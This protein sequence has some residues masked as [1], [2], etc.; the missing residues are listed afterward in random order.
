MD[1]GQLL[2]RAAPD[3]AYA[4]GF[5]DNSTSNVMYSNVAPATYTAASTNG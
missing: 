2:Y 5:G 4:A 1:H 3:A